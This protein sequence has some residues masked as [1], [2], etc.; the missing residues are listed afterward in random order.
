MIKINKLGYFDPLE[1]RFKVTAYQLL[2]FG[3]VVYEKAA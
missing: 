3:R 2:L 1:H